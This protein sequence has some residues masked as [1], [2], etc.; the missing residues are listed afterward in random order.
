MP[1]SSFTDLL[2]M[3]T[4]AGSGNVLCV[5]E[6]EMPLDDIIRESS[7]KLLVCRRDGPALLLPCFGSTEQENKS[8][9]DDM[10]TFLQGD[11]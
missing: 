11:C 8:H 10:K 6:I 5:Q 2:C 3:C 7:L 1:A 9:E 4:L